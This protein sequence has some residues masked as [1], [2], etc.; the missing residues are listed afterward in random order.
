MKRA[1]EKLPV[2]PDLTLIDG[3]FVPK[4][5]KNCKSIING[6]EKVKISAASIIAKVYRDKLM[7][8][9]AQEFLIMLGKVIWVWNQGSFRRS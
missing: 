3:N 5:L 7:I 9:L 4:G 1:V 8:K 6:D 2:K